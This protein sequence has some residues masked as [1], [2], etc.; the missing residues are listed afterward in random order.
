MSRLRAFG[1][2]RRLLIS[3]ALA[4]L[5]LLVPATASAAPK[6][7]AELRCTEKGTAHRDLLRGTPGFDVIC[8]GGGDD[9]IR[10]LDGNDYAYGGRGTDLISGGAGSDHLFGGPG[11]DRISGGAGKD[12]LYGDAGDD[13]LA[14]GDAADVLYGDLGD[15]RLNDGPGLDHVSGGPGADSGDPNDALDYAE[16]PSGRSGYCKISMHVDIPFSFPCPS[17]SRNFGNCA[18]RTAYSN[19]AWAVYVESLPLMFAQFGWFDG[20]GHKNTNYNAIQAAVPTATL[21]GW[22]PH[23]ASPN[24]AIERAWTILQ[25]SSVYYTPLSG[26]PGTPGGPLWLNF[27][28]GYVG[29][30]MYIDGYLYRN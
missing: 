29:A 19:P 30:D 23:A 12:F 3:L 24:Y 4:S 2:P 1:P 11:R 5:A 13:R 21:Q 26:Y 28:N 10:S 27:V 8:A 16:C 6:T 7:H 18:G 22:V 20:L 17:F 9:T 15:D 14:S 25:P